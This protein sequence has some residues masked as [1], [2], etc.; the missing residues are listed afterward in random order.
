MRPS[1]TPAWQDGPHQF[2]ADLH[3]V[4][5]LGEKGY[6]F[7]VLTD[8]ELHRE[9]AA[10]LR[11]YKVVLTG[12][13]S[14][15]CSGAM[16][17]AAQEYLNGGGRLMYLSGN[18]FYWVTALDPTTQTSI[19]IR[20]RGPAQRTW[21]P[22]PGEAHL[23]STGELGGLWRYR[24]RPPQTWLGVGFTAEGTGPGRPYV[25]QPGSFDS[26]A[27]FVFEGIGADEPIGDVPCLVYGHGAAGYEIDRFDPA[28]GTPEHAILLATADGFTDDFQAAAEEVLMGDSQQGGT[29]SPL[30]RADMVL[31]EYPNGGAVFSTGSISWCACLSH[32]SYDNTVSR[33]TSNVLDGFLQEELPR[34]ERQ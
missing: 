11:D 12:S 28:Q 33:V 24:G 25:R 14:E 19:E 16:L 34:R 31:I 10:R 27:A 30:V 9:G 20:R 17:D 29:V 23:S 6:S 15:Y 13:H 5:W 8:L 21:E 22:E 4:D 18:G 26:R 2:P 3:L 7:D 1:C 32:N